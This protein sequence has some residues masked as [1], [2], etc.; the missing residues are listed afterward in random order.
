MAKHKREDRGRRPGGLTDIPCAFS[1]K[2]TQL[3]VRT[4][5]SLI[6][7]VDF[8]LSQISIHVYVGRNKKLQNDV[9][10]DKDMLTKRYHH[11]QKS[12]G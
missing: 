8:I 3:Y 9:R 12:E 11:H 1:L 10:N 7:S 5:D 4:Q 2:F 6:L